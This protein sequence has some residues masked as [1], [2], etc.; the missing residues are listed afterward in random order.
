LQQQQQLL[1]F[2]FVSIDASIKG[3]GH[4]GIQYLL[5][6]KL[7]SECVSFLNPE[8]QSILEILKRGE[9]NSPDLNL[10]SLINF[11]LRRSGESVPNELVDLKKNLFSSKNPW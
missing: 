10:D 11:I 8:Y 5:S 4:L 3:Q 7:V 1:L 6:F 2:K 9:K